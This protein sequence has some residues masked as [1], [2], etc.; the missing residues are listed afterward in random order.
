MISFPLSN[1]IGDSDYEIFIQFGAHDESLY[2]HQHKDYAELVIVMDGTALHRVN[3]ETYFIKKGDVFVISKD[4]I[5]G[6]E[7]PLDFKICNIMFKENRLMQLSTNTRGLMGFHGLFM[8]E[9]YFNKNDIFQSRLHLDMVN[10]EKIKDRLYDLHKEYIHKEMGW[11]DY[12]IAGFNQ[13]IILLSRLYENK[14]HTYDETIILIS[15]SIA[16][17]ESNFHHPIT[18]EELAQMSNMSVR[19]FSRI[20][21][22]TYK[23]SPNKYLIHLRLQQ[24][25]RLLKTTDLAITDISFRSGFSSVSYFNRLFKE[26]YHMTPKKYRL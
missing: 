17:M 8:I 6:Y 19:H 18:L 10:Y 7:N 16:Y 22:A 26:M 21:K 13:L 20:F 23:T 4:T 24:A 11:E 14:H 3:D 5:H 2:M 1:F 15:K 25:S 9:P 12:F